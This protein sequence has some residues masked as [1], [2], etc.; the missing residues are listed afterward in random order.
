MLAVARERLPPRVELRQGWAEALPYADGAFDVV[1]SCNVLHYVREPVAALRDMLRVLRPGGALG[2]T[3]WS[4]DHFACRVHDWY[5]RWFNAAHF[6]TYRTRQLW[7]LLT[8]A[9]AA[10]IRIDRYKVTWLWGLMT[11]IARKPA[12]DV[13]PQCSG[14]CSP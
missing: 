5:L 6:R 8:R 11:A 1:V 14:P 3:D 10:E 2:I 9:G 12:W 7:D 4:A 13:R